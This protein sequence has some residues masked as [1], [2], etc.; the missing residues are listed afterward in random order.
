M[1]RVPTPSRQQVRCAWGPSLLAILP[2]LT[3]AFH[4]ERLCQPGPQFRQPEQIIPFPAIRAAPPPSRPP[5]TS[6]PAAPAAPARIRHQRR[7]RRRFLRPP[8]APPIPPARPWP[9]RP[10]GVA[11]ARSVYYSHIARSVLDHLFAHRRWRSSRSSLMPQ[12]NGDAPGR[13]S[14]ASAANA[15][16]P[17]LLRGPPAASIKPVAMA[18]RQP[19]PP[20]P[21]RTRA[22]HLHLAMPAPLA[23]G[24]TSRIDPGCPRKKETERLHRR[25]ILTRPFASSWRW[26]AIIAII[27][28]SLCSPD[29]RLGRGAA[30]TAAT[31]PVPSGLRQPERDTPLGWAPMASGRQPRRSNSELAAFVEQL[32]DRPRAAEIWGRAAQPFTALTTAVSAAPSRRS[33]SAPA[34]I[35]TAHRPRPRESGPFE[36]IDA[37]AQRRQARRASSTNAANTVG[38]RKPSSHRGERR[39]STSARLQKPAVW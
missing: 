37:A 26:A 28:R 13:R 39:N 18:A 4:F 21:A 16:Y 17:T 32:K 8:R 14:L 23:S 20:P 30:S 31:A 19:P 7:Q 36:W 2:P 27:P 22:L 6:S 15:V 10:K 3:A 29:S 35:A 5:T 33:L 24:S 34:H 38:C 11:A 12:A 9:S 25:A 1:P